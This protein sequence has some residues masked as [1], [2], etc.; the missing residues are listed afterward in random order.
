M[1][2]ALVNTNVAE[3]AA[4]SQEKMAAVLGYIMHHARDSQVWS[5]LPHMAI[6]LPGGLTLHGLMLV[7]SAFVVLLLFGVVYRRSATVPTG[8]TNLME[9]F[10]QFI[11]DQIAIP[12]LGEE[13]GRRFTPIFCSF[14][15]FIVIMNL[16]GLVPGLASATSNVNV[17]GALAFISL[18]FMIFGAMYRHGVVGFFKGF[19]P[20]GIPW[21]VLIIM[22][23]IEIVGLFI[24]SMALM[25]RLFANMLAGHIVIFS[26][27]GLIFVFGLVALPI[28]VMA[29]GIYLLEVFVAIFQAFIFTLLSAVFIGQRYH[30]AH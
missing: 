10:V 28:M 20:H 25:I 14:F 2:E 6:P 30:P 29:L 26:L 12:N 27:L 15:F 3:V 19:I 24:K 9:F 16:V 17:T 7:F 13:D 21:F 4:G 1:S 22:V 23:P 18:C 8:M 5:P 11:R